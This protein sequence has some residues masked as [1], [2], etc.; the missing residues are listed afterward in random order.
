GGGHEQFEQRRA[1]GAAHGSGPEPVVL[2]SDHVSERQR[3]APIFLP[4]AL[5]VYAWTK[6]SVAKLALSWPPA[7]PGLSM[8][9]GPPASMTPAT[10]EYGGAANTRSSATV[11]RRATAAPYTSTVE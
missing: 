9:T 10:S 8:P 1:S 5:S 4:P 7:S 6:S 2:P 3:S 11:E